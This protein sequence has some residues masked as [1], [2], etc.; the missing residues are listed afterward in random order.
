[1]KMNKVPIV[2]CFDDNLIL[3][4]AVC[5]FSLLSHARPNTFYDIFIIHDNKAHFPKEGVLDR[6]KNR[7]ENFQLSYRQIDDSFSKAF[8]IRGI[9]QTTYYRLAIPEL[10]PEYNVI[11]YHDVDVIF[12]SDL[13]DV[14]HNTN[15]GEAYFAGVVSSGGLNERGRKRTEELG[16]DWETYILAGNL[17]INS[18][19]IRKDKL[20]E[21]FKYHALNFKYEY[22]DMDII[23]VVCKGRMKRMPPSFCGTVDIFRLASKKVKQE[24]YS[25]DELTSLL[26]DGIVHFNGPK[27][28]KD[29]CPN[30]DIWWEYY[31][32]SDFFNHNFYF[33][34]FNDKMFYLDQLSLWKRLKVLLRFF[35]TNRFIS[36][37]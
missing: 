2:F 9:N 28:W 16:L 24:L 35:K 36:N 20:V 33:D 3:P 26:Y 37:N 23:N 12:R 29:L 4:A 31:R 5:I 15:L 22:Q 10:I 6:L 27:P 8:E 19:L 34:F 7:F 17:I 25:Q 13:S 1:M 11:M 30:F 32:K 21:L 14:F 18:S